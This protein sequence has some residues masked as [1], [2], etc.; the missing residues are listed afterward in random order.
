MIND[1]LRERATLLIF[2][3]V[4]NVCVWIMFAVVRSPLVAV[5]SASV[6]FVQKKPAP[7]KTISGI[8]TRL[9]INSLGLDLAVKVGSFNQANVSWTLDDYNA[10]F[11]DSSVPANNS[12][13]VTLIYGHAREP[14]FSRLT[15]LRPGARAVVTADNDVSFEYV[16]DSVREVLPTDVSLFTP[17][18]SPRLILQ[19]CSGPWDRY[20]SLY[21]FTYERVAPV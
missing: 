19:T 4:G 17:E 13:G 6:V 8:P 20:R 16:Y 5:A 7:P 14:V 15:A 11:A 1:G 10:Y 3:L 21:T 2:I 12:N 9:T 18:G